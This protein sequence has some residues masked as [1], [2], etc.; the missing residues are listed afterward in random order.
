VWLRITDGEEESS[1]I[2]MELQHRLADRRDAYNRRMGQFESKKQEHDRVHGELLRLDLDIKSSEQVRY[3]LQKTSEIA[4]ET[5][6]KTLEE[7]VTNALQ[8][9]FGA[10]YQFVIEL[11]QKAGRSEA[12]FY[13]ESPAPKEKPEDPTVM[14]RLAPEESR[15]GGIVDIVGLTLRLAVMRIHQNPKVADVLL[16]DEPA[17]MLSAEFGQLLAAFL[18]WAS[19]YFKMQVL[20]VTHN[21]SLAAVAD[22]PFLVTQVGGTSQITG[23]NTNASE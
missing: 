23:G 5:A 4:R 7:T 1:M 20:M 17:K 18:K 15:G 8:Y 12:T 6:R 16:L 13:V 2:L 9:V 11:E 14:M 3:L 22:R 19:S 21:E 10:D